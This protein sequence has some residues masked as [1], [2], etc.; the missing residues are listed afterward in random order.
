MLKTNEKSL[1]IENIKNSQME[2]LE[3]KKMITKIKSLLD[4]LN[5]RMEGT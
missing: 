5:N 3:L 4:G 2:T 1:S